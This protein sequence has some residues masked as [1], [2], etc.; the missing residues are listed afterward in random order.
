MAKIP[1]HEGQ[2]PPWLG[3]HLASQRERPGVMPP[4]LRRHLETATGTARRFGDR[5]VAGLCDR[6][7]ARVLRGL[8]D[9]PIGAEAT[10]DAMAL[11]DV[12]T[13]A[14]A[15]MAGRVT[16]RLRG[17]M[18]RTLTLHRR[19]PRDIAE[20]PIG[21]WD[22]CGTVRVVPEHRCAPR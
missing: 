10:A 5:A 1:R 8:D 14:R 6:C 9:D 3:S 4:W 17:S 16:Y 12:L 2:V 20:Q 13:E 22:V 7:G 11:P 21:S 19:S 15:R 18:P